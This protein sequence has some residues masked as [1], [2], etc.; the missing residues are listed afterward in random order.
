MLKLLSNT[1]YLKGLGTG[2]VFGVVLGFTGSFFIPSTFTYLTLG[3]VGAGLGG[4]LLYK[5]V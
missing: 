4:L 3:A 5:A 1:T 2:L